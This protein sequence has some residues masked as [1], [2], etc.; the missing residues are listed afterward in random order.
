MHGIKHFGEGTAGEGG[1]FGPKMLTHGL[2]RV[3]AWLTLEGNNWLGF[4]HSCFT[5]D[6][7]G[8]HFLN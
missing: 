4:G 5:K 7:K 1:G 2:L 3:G 8:L 6:P